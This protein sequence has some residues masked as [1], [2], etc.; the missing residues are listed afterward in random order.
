MR[1]ELSV[2]DFA[3]GGERAT[4]PWLAEGCPGRGNQVSQVMTLV[5][6]Q[7]GGDTQLVSPSPDKCLFEGLFR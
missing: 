3:E 7:M 4:K 5:L 1:R 2:R 6:V